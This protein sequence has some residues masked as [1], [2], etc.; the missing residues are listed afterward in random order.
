MPPQGLPPPPPPHNNPSNPPGQPPTEAEWQIN[1]KI[2]LNHIPS[3]DG[4]GESIIDYISEMSSYAILGDKMNI[5]IGKIAP[6]KWTGSAR[7]WWDAIPILDRRFYGQNWDSLLVALQ[8]YY[9]NDTW[10]Q[11]RDQEFQEMKFRQKDHHNEQPVEFL[12]RRIRYHSFL[13]PTETDGPTAIA[14]VLRTQPPEWGVTLNPH[15]SPTF[16]E[17][18]NTA[19]K[20]QAILESSWVTGEAVRKASSSASYTGSARRRS[21]R[22][23]RDANLAEAGEVE[24]FSETTDSGEEREVLFTTKKAKGDSKKSLKKRMEWPHGKSINGYEFRRDDSVESAPPPKGNCY[25]C[26]SPKHVFRDCPHHGRFSLL[27][28]ANLIDLDVDPAEEDAAN[29]EYLASLQQSNSSSAYES[30]GSPSE[31]IRIAL[32]VETDVH[33]PAT[34]T[35]TD[36]PRN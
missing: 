19:R 22:R 1:N 17:L 36:L 2:N 13:H 26:T 12:Q 25:I 10:T 31:E 15:T 6:L 33:G 5:G 11:Q 18:L 21:F 7:A 20:Y 34:A 24:E 8:W 29:Q 14:R 27:R 16:F 35:E 28:E 9:M 30:V 23:R 3:W 32:E 4:R